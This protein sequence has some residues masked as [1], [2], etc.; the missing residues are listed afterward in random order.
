M[1]FLNNQSSN[2]STI[3]TPSQPP[4]PS[5]TVKGVTT[6]GLSKEQEPSQTV[7]AEVATEITTEM[8]I[9]KEVEQ[10]GV[11]KIQETIEIPPSV[12]KLGVTPVGSSASTTTTIPTVVLPIPDQ[13]I[14]AG[15]HTRLLNSLHWLAWWCIRKLKKAHVALKVIHGK[16]VRV[17]I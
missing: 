2:K 4:L 17:K 8:E 13:K 9:P 15:L 6:T 5:A 7:S 3:S 16:I 1:T 14:I 10:A 11:K 12:K